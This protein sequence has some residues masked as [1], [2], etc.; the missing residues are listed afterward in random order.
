[1]MRFTL[2]ALFS[3]ALVACDPEVI[4]RPPTQ[5]TVRVYGSP[6]V[7]QQ[8]ARLGINVSTWDGR[9]W[10]SSK[11]VR[12]ELEGLEWPVDVPVVP[13]PDQA[14]N[15]RFEVVVV[16]LDA[17]DN[18]LA[19]AR[20]ITSFVPHEQRLLA[21]SLAPCPGMAVCEADPACHGHDCATCIDTMCADTPDH[22]GS[23]LPPLD[24]NADVDPLTGDDAGDGETHEPDASVP[25]DGDGDGDGDELDAGIECDSG[26]K[27]EGNIRQE[28]KAGKWT[29]SKVCEFACF[30]DDCTGICK[31]TEDVRCGDPDQL[32]AEI[33][34]PNGK[35]MPNPEENDGDGACKYLCV[36]GE[37]KGDCKPGTSQCN[38]NQRQQCNEQ[39]AWEDAELCG[40]LCREGSCSG[41]SSCELVLTTC[42]AENSSCCVSH[43][44]PGGTYYRSY[45]NYAYLDMG[46]PAMVSAFRLDRF[47]VTV[48]RFRTFLGAYERGVRPRG[49][50]GANPSVHG[51]MGWSS[52]WDDDLPVD[53]AEFEQKLTS[54]PDASFVHNAPANDNKP[55]NCVSWYEAMAFC[56]WDEGRLPTEAEWNFAAAGG[57]DQR[58]FPWSTTADATGLDDAH[59]VYYP[60]DLADVGSRPPGDGKWGQAD[61]GGNVQEWMVDSY[62]DPYDL[63]LCNDCADLQETGVRVRRGGAYSAIEDAVYVG[64]RSFLQAKDRQ[65]KVGFRCARAE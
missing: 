35:F 28:C 7:V 59:V 17:V 62:Q 25:G 53:R 50:N 11:P 18:R 13:G 19:E 27:C 14:K 6:T 20:Y 30:D 1:M 60:A 10:Q 12:I 63:T 57:S 49:G 34:G 41:L 29:F 58:V 9:A 37:C 36:D 16:A 22:P 5:V 64:F 44:V 15:V 31:P 55:I 46:F 23:T 42:G 33:C 38:D 8:T 21:L 45:D 2:A 40:D 39:G 51:D 4:E 61:L 54:C 47:E 48:A 56:I 32:V 3:L 65:G 52:S 43:R 26:F 24:P